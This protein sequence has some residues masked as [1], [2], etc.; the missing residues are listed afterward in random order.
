[1]AKSYG[2]RYVELGSPSSPVNLT[3]YM[4]PALAKVAGV[5]ADGT[6]SHKL[7]IG[8]DAGPLHRP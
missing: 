5:S 3:L 7:I 1:V 4:R 8:S 6:G 2:R